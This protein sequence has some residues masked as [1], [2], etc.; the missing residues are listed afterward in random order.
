[1]EPATGIAAMSCHRLFTAVRLVLLATVLNLAG[2]ARPAG[3][4]AVVSMVADAITHNYSQ[5]TSADLLFSMTFEDRQVSSA[6]K[7]EIVT[8]NGTRLQFDVMPRFEWSMHYTLAGSKIKTEIRDLANEHDELLAFDGETWLRYVPHHKAAWQL[9]ESDRDRLWPVDVRDVG[10]P[11]ARK[12]VLTLIHE[13][14]V[15]DA[16][17]G[18]DDAGKEV[19]SIMI[20]NATAGR[21]LFTFDSSV[22][23]LPVSVEVA[24]K[25]GRPTMRYDIQYERLPNTHI[26]FLKE[27]VCKIRGRH[28]TS[29]ADA[30]PQSGRLSLKEVIRVNQPIDSSDLAIVLPKGT[31]FHDNVQRAA[32]V[33]G[34]PLPRGTSSLP[35]PLYVIPIVC[36]AIALAYLLLRRGSAA[37]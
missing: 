27:G 1:M 24:E 28:N 26:W 11:D 34:Q 31:R 37:A 22:N 35:S 23:F 36:V 29:N 15:L 30:W 33:V 18:K 2:T 32:S 8:E 14:D 20:S 9:F 21:V 6:R 16:E 5:L 4:E 13:S 3:H 25:D 10:S 12:S 19:A 7:K 17:L